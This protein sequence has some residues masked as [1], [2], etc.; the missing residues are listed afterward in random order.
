MQS[1]RVT[2]R[3]HSGGW[4]GKIIGSCGG[5]RFPKADLAQVLVLLNC[6]FAFSF[7]S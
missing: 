1:Y 4:P 5:V 3:M 6:G 2:N 7:L